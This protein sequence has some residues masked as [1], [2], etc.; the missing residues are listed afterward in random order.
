MMV[1]MVK[2]HPSSV[3]VRVVSV[4]NGASVDVDFLIVFV[5]LLFRPTNP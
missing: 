4:A 1:P 2:L 5:I 3:E